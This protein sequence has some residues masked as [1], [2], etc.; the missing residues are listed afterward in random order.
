MATAD[1]ESEWAERSVRG[2]VEELTRHFPCVLMTGARQV[3]K[4]SLLQHMLP[5]GMRYVTLDDFQQAEF[6]RN[7]P[8][9]FLEMYPAPLCIDEVQY[10]PQLFRAIKIKVDADRR[11]G[12]YW[13]TGSQR[14]RM[15]KGVSET[16][17]GRIGIVDLYS[18]SQQEMYGNPA[19]GIYTPATPAESVSLASVCDI[20]ALY[21]RIFR[22]GYP[23]LYRDPGMPWFDYY[24]DYVQTYVARDVRE[25]TQVGNHV[26]FMKLMSS[27]ALRTGQQLVYADLAR[28]AGIS[29]KTAAAWV[30]ILVASGI[31]ELLQP[32]YVNTTKRLSKTPK[33]YFTD[34]GLCCWL[35][36]WHST[37]QILNSA[38]SGAILETWVYGQLVRRYAA[39]GRQP[40]IS[41]YRDLDGAE[42][43]FVIEQDGGVF[44]MEVKRTT[45]PMVADLHWCTKIPVSPWAKLMPPVLLSTAQEARPMPHGAFAFPI[46]AL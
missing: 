27:A 43:D 26:A 21:E 1:T 38:A 25:L 34:T 32:Y 35:A 28:D 41:Y 17:A 44:P 37:E 2:K 15:M 40:A 39:E 4:S 3:G 18:L 33:L 23:A 12:M 30:S 9:G 24:R 22:G 36:G 46:S 16:L 8:L 13:M 20:A 14:F 6:A 42:V 45:T 29:P 5:Q 10:A 31:V 19:A 11:P 7:D